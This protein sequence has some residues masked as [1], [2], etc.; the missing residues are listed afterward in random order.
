MLGK[1][2]CEDAGRGT[3]GAATPGASDQPEVV[4]LAPDYVC[5]LSPLG[6]LA[7]AHM[8]AHHCPSLAPIG[9]P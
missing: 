6:A 9:H 4:A 2:A 1:G 8:E 3:G 7:C 5:L